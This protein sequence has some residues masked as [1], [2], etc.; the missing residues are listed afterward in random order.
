MNNAT[1]IRTTNT[2]SEVLI[3]EIVSPLSEDKS[4]SVRSVT[5]DPGTV[6]TA[7]VLTDTLPVP[8]DC[9]L[10][11]T[12]VRA[13]VDQHDNR[14]FVG[15]DLLEALGLTTGTA[16][17]YMRLDA[18]EKA[19]VSR[20][21][22]GLHP[23]KSMTLISEPGLYRFIF[24]S[25]KP[26]AKCFVDWICHEVLPSIRKTGAYFTPQ[27]I[28]DLMDDSDEAILKFAARIAERAIV[29]Q[30]TLREKAAG[31]Y[32]LKLTPFSSSSPANRRKDLLINRIEYQGDRA[33]LR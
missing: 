8:A 13:F 21:D 11:G 30:E 16:K 32:V 6:L 7:K 4:S 20:S 5:H 29:E 10:C 14:W 17:H 18:D 22:L 2:E 25:R 12:K 28:Q 27:K 26:E 3:P 15:T 19:L 33:V 24:R 1:A 9:D 23:G 31:T